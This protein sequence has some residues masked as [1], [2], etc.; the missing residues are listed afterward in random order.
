MNISLT[1]NM[2]NS[3]HGQSYHVH[4]TRGI[5]GIDDSYITRME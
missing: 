3:G 2:G 1:W 4:G 5:K